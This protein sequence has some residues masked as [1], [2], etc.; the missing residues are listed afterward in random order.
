MC[1]VG[2]ENREGDNQ[3][4]GLCPGRKVGWGYWLE[5]GVLYLLSWSW[6]LVARGVVSVLVLVLVDFLSPLVRVVSAGC[7]WTV[8][9]TRG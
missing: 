7:K 5:G 6:F 8:W 1:V 2:V 9:C 4:W 3:S